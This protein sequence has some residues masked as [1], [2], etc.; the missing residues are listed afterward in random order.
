[1]AARQIMSMAS[2]MHC[3]LHASS[4]VRQGKIIFLHAAY[5]RLPISH[6]PCLGKDAVGCGLS[7]RGPNAHCQA[8]EASYRL[9]RRGQLLLFESQQGLLHTVF[10]TPFDTTHDTGCK[11]V[12]SAHML[13]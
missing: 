9:M 11:L 3:A 10:W 12:A 8:L 7:D 2:G 4:D 13:A 6:E 1:M 5:Q